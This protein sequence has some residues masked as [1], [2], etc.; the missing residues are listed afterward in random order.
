ML[1]FH[2]EG[3]FDISYISKFD[4]GPFFSCDFLKHLI[5]Q[6]EKSILLENSWLKSPLSVGMHVQIVKCLSWLTKMDK[7]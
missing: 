7:F 4:V 1:S 3:I 2:T 6:V 5:C